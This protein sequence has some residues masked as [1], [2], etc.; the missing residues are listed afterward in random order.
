MRLPIAL[1]SAIVVATATLGTARS[2]P[3][4][5]LVHVRINFQPAGSPAPA[6][7]LADSG[8]VFGDRGNG[9]SYGWNADNSANT[10][11][12]NATADQRYDTLIH[13]Q[14][15][16]NFTWEIALPRGLYT[17]KIVAGDPSFID[18]HY[19]FEVEGSLRPSPVLGNTPTADNPWAEGVQTARVETGRLR[20]RSRSTGDVGVN[21]KLCFLEIVQHWG[22]SVN[23]QPAGAAVPTGY[24]ADTGETYGSRGY[25]YTYGWSTNNTASAR[26]RNQLSDQRYDTLTHM[27]LG[28]ANA[29]WKIAVPA[30]G[31]YSS[32]IVAGD[33]G[34]IDSLYSID[35]NGGFGVRGIP[36]TTQRFIEANGTPEILP[37]NLTLTLSNGAGAVNNKLAFFEIDGQKPPAFADEFQ[38]LFNRSASSLGPA[39]TQ[40]GQWTVQTS[41]ES[42]TANGVATNTER[43]SA[44]MQTA[45]FFPQTNYEIESRASGFGNTTGLSP[46]DAVS[47]I[48]GGPDGGSNP[49]WN[50]YRVAYHPWAG[51]FVLERVQTPASGG[52]IVHDVLATAPGPHL[53]VTG[54]VSWKIEHTDLG[55][56]RFFVDTGSGY[57]ATPIFQVRDTTFE[58]RPL[59]HFGWLLESEAPGPFNV[60]SIAARYWSESF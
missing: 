57:S 4:Q 14:K 49:A 10:R 51:D 39:W 35:M 13:L 47:L 44:I 17:V 33:P 36:T 7:Y 1:A 37:G 38:D 24:V 30:P 32:H 56:I 28:G 46:S 50:F 23:F 53:P 15:G 40:V 12:R 54:W 31:L 22:A 34:F 60:D 48:F 25:G 5:N 45:Q 41:D 9:W 26:D 16:G 55:F 29:S 59:G 11:D 27:Q 6:G 43:G 42:H 18:S 20:I 19:A 8:A 21:D 3:A 58:M 2:A 52:E